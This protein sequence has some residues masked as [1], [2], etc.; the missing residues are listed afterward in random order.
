MFPVRYA[1]MQNEWSLVVECAMRCKS[2]GRRNSF[3]SSLRGTVLTRGIKM[4]PM[5]GAR[6]IWEYRVYVIQ[7]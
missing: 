5:K 3:V 6:I 2:R 1:K 7:Y 4:V